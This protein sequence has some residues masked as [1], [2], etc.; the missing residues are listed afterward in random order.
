MLGPNRDLG[1]VTP[2][3]TRSTPVWTAWRRMTTSMPISRC[4]L[5]PNGRCALSSSSSSGKPLAM[6]P[7][8][9]ASP[10]GTRC[11]LATHPPHLTAQLLDDPHSA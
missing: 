4:C 10:P 8:L 7:H 1:M 5:N 6:T 11:G 3:W 2:C 9:L